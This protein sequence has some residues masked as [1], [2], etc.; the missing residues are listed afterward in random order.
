MLIHNFLKDTIKKKTK[1]CDYLGQIRLHFNLLVFSIFTGLSFEW[2]VCSFLI[3]AGLT[4]LLKFNGI[5]KEKK[6]NEKSKTKQ[7]KKKLYG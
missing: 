4:L 1:G 5:F 6:S 2:F 7:K 3:P